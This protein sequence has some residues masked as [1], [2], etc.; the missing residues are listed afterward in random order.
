MPDIYLVGVDGSDGA[1]RA[2]RFAAVQAKKAGA[3]LLIAHVIEWS[4]FEV[5]LAPELSSRPTVREREI[6]RATETI[7]KPAQ[8]L[9]SGD[10]E[11]ETVLHHGHAAQGLVELAKEHKASQIFI[12]RQGQ[13]DL[14]DLLHGS[15]A[16]NLARIASVPVT[17]VP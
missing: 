15:V 16:G 6:G 11:V 5:M 3:K 10:V 4:R 1:K 8:G 2:V 13:A 14:G 17:V 9:A 7:L 12:G